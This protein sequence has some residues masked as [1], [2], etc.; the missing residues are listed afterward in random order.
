MVSHRFGGYNISSETE[1]KA[2]GLEKMIDRAW[3][4][5]ALKNI[6]K[7]PCAY[8]TRKEIEKYYR[9][10]SIGDKAA[11]AILNTIYCNMKSLKSWD[12]T[13]QSVEY[14]LNLLPVRLST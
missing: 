9:N 7:S 11:I 2:N 12:A 1:N 10:A 6:P 3:L 5:D 14:L 8:Q 4:D 13:L